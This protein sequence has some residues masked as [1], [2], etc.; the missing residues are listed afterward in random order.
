MWSMS[1]FYN[2]SWCKLYIIL[3]V[4]Q[5]PT[6]LCLQGDV[7]QIILHDGV[8]GLDNEAV[9]FNLSKLGDERLLVYTLPEN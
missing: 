3:L 1:H 5:L 4:T 6:C 7:E 8:T 2:Y 9:H